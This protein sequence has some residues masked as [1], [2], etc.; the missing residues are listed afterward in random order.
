MTAPRPI[1][2]EEHEIFRETVRRF[3][4]RE[5]VP[6]HAQWEK[7][8]QISREAWLKAGERGLL[9]CSIPSDRRIA[10]PRMNRHP[11]RFR[12]GLRANHHDS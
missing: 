1:F 6:H 4:E 3:V 11:V 9:C 8:G 2:E 12:R 7:D 10:R 5:I